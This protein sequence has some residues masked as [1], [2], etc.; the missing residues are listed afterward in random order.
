M[1]VYTLR[2]TASSKRVWVNAQIAVDIGIADVG[3]STCPDRVSAQHDAVS[4]DVAGS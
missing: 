3:V 2:E 4:D 1:N